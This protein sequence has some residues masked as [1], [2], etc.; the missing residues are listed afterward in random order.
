MG[1]TMDSTT[2]RKARLQAI[3][4]RWFTEPLPPEFPPLPGASSPPPTTCHELVTG[5]RLL[6]AFSTLH[7]DP[8]AA[9]IAMDEAVAADREQNLDHYGV[10]DPP[11]LLRDLSRQFDQAPAGQISPDVIKRAAVVLD[12]LRHDSEEMAASAVGTDEASRVL[13]ASHQADAQAVAHA[14]DLVSELA[15]E[16]GVSLPLRRGN[17]RS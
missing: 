1:R 4:D 5:T 15:R 8:G 16:V 6:P 10:E 12:T 2:P 7:H 3:R 14:Q 11:A 9:G 17:R 13:Q